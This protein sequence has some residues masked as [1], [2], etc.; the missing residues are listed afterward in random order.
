M[1]L[2]KKVIFTLLIILFVQG[3]A[4]MGS[5]YTAT[6]YPYEKNEDVKKILKG[7]NFFICSKNDNYNLVSEEKMDEQNQADIKNFVK[8]LS[9]TTEK[10]IITY[11]I[12]DSDVLWF[13]IYKKGKEIFILDN[14]DE[15]F[16]GGK[17]ILKEKED[18]SKIFNIDKNLWKTEITKAKFEEC[19]FADEFLMTLI[20]ILKLPIWVEGI[21]YTYLSED[22]DFMSNL[23]DAGVKIEKY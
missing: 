7:R 10:P 4:F 19:I 23:K 20:K 22:E 1:K 15:Y 8:K 16:S 18:I 17:F 13:S 2:N 3:Q 11:M 9:A 14:T 5:F 6:L 12:H 21:G